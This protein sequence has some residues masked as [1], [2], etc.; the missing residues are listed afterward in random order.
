MNPK[1]ILLGDF[2][3][4]FYWFLPVKFCSF[5]NRMHSWQLKLTVIAKKQS[6]ARGKVGA[7][8]RCRSQEEKQEHPYA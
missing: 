7:L 8:T 2:T 3:G 4:D 1:E 6:K 5:Q